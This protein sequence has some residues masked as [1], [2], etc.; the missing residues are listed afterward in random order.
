M[1]CSLKC[2]VITD[3]KAKKWLERIVCHY[4]LKLTSFL[5]SSGDYSE[6][7]LALTLVFPHIFLLYVPLYALSLLSLSGGQS[8]SLPCMSTKMPNLVWK[9]VFASGIWRLEQL[10]AVGT[11]M[12]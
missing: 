6:L 8:L 10:N 2:A 4:R 5:L 12:W 7:F 11:E 9:L 1:G 3:N